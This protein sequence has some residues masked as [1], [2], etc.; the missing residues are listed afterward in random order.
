[1]KHATVKLGDYTVPLIGIDENAT[2][3]QCDECKKVKHL[4]TI[5]ITD[6]GRFQCLI[7]QA[8]ESLRLSL[9]TNK[10]HNDHDR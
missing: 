5:R 4:S 10:G 6:Q 1:M 8:K 2:K 9:T 3:E 7:C